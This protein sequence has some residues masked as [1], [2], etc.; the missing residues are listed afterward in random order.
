MRS[1][2]VAVKDPEGQL[3]MYV[4]KAA[5]AIA[6]SEDP[7]PAGLRT[8]GR[9]AWVEAELLDASTG[10][11]LY[12]VVDRAAD[13]IPRPKPIETWGDLHRSFVAW[14]DHITERM[15]ALRDRKP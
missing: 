9:N 14:G 3:D 10:E 11:V 4:T 5:P 7:L 6:D 13:V 1:A 12:A 2:L 8:F 15:T